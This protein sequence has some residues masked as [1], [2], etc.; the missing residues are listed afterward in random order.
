MNTARTCWMVTATLLSAMAAAAESRPNVLFLAVDDLR[1]ELACYGAVHVHSPHIDS[2]AATGRRFEA[3]Y[4]QQAVC[5]PSRTSLMTG[6]RPDTT[7][8]VGNHAHFRAQLPDVVTLPQYFRQH[9]Y[10][11]AAIGKIYHGVFPEGASRTKWDTMGDPPSWSVP[12]VRFGPRYYYTE[13]GIAAARQQF[14][15]MY[16]PP[17]PAPDDWTKKLVFGPATE[18]PDVADNVLYDGQVAD[19]AIAFLRQHTQQSGGQHKPL[20]LAVGFIKPHSPYVAPQKYFD[21]YQEMPLPAIDALPQG[22]PAF[23][24]HNSGELRRYTDQPAEGPISPAAQRRVRQAYYACVSYIDAQ[25]GRVLTALEETGLADNTIVVLLGDHGYHLGE[26]GLWGKTTN[27]ELDTRVPLIVRAPDMPAPGKS[28]A[29]LVELLDVYPTLAD[30]AG[31]PAPAQVEGVSFVP[32]LQ[33]PNHPGKTAAVSQ[34]PRG[35]RMGYSLRTSTHRLTQWVDQKTGQRSAT[36]LYHYAAAIDGATART[37]TINLAASRPALVAQLSRQLTP[38]IKPP[39]PEAGTPNDQTAPDETPGDGPHEGFESANPGSFQRLS[40]S[41]GEWSTDEGRTVIDNRHAATGRQSLQLTGGKKTIVR[42]RLND[43]LDTSGDLHFAAER[44]TRRAPF[45]FQ[46]EKLSDG[47]WTNVFDGSQVRVGRPFLSRVRV[48]LRDD[49]ITQ[50]RW[51]VTSPPG[52]GVLIDDLCLV[53]AGADDAPAITHARPA[54]PPVAARAEAVGSAFVMAPAEDKTPPARLLM[55]PVFSDHMVLQANVDVP[56][57]GK[58]VP[59]AP[60][61][62]QL[63]STSQTTRADA[64]GDWRL[65]LPPLPINPQGQP[66][67]ITSGSQKLVIRD[68]LL[69]EVWL[70]AGQ[71]NMEWRLQQSADAQFALRDADDHLLRLLHLKGGARGSSGRYTTAHIARL[72]PSAFFAGQ[73]QLSS[74][75]VAADFSAVAWYFGQHLR[76]RRDVPIGLICPALGGTPTEAWISQEALQADPELTGLVAG[77]WLDNPRLGEFCRSRGRA[78]LA[79]A[80]QA[81][82]PLPGDQH[83][84]NHSFKPGFVWNA[85]EDTR[86]FRVRG[87]I[88]YQGESNAESP[89]RVREHG[90]LLPL[91]IQQ[92]RDAQQC[93]DLPFLHVQLPALDRPEWPWMRDDQRRITERTENVG[94]VVTIDTGHRTNVHPT[95]KRPIGL[96]LAELAIGMTEPAR[97]ADVFQSPAVT[98]HAKDRGQLTVTFA[99]CG[100]GLRTTDGGAPRHFEVCGKDGRFHPATA[101]IVSANSVQLTCQSVSEPQHVRYAWQPW[102]EPAVNLINSGQ[103]PASP[104][105]TETESTSLARRLSAR[106]TD[107]RLPR[108][109]NILF[110]VSEDNSEHL[111]CYGESRVHTPHLDQLAAEGVRYTRAYVPYSVCSPSRAAFLTGLYPRQTGHIGLATHRFAMAV[112]YPTLPALLHEAGYYTGFLGKTHINPEHLVEDHIDHRAIRGA[113]FS[114]TTSITEYAREAARVFRTAQQRDQPFL[115]IVNFA[116]AHRK[117]VARSRAGFPSQQ[118]SDPVRP[119][120]WIGSDTPHLREEIRDYFNCMNRLDEGIGLVLNELRNAGQLDN[121]LIVYIS[122]HGADFPRGKGSVYE[123]GVRIPMIVRHPSQFL[124]GDVEEGFVTTLDLLP[125]MLKT[126]GLPV[127]DWLPG[128]P[129]QD[130]AAR[131]APLQPYV[132]TFTTGSSPNLLYVQFG[133]RDERYKLIRNPARTVNRLAAS[134]YVNSRIP[135]EQQ[136]HNFLHPA[137]LELYDLQSD[138]HEWHNLAES[139]QH[140]AMRDRL[141]QAMRAFQHRIG[142]PF[143]SE[144]NLN[145]F[146]QEQTD[147]QARDYRRADFHWPHRKMFELADPRRGDSQKTP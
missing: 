56:V 43:G 85:L 31:L 80:L 112:D 19:A 130:V 128:R 101:Q 119:F 118:L 115:L 95:A 14:Q 63:G 92:W 37:E 62:V 86:P 30:L 9:G 33:D 138:P 57:W 87:V 58:C 114:K 127:P 97:A 66:L 79:G 4:C 144:D 50:L 104:F 105:T 137:E 90:R 111:G 141:L 42:L 124:T 21:L 88:W 11:A 64:H 94:M 8:V 25:A 36:E 147:H 102:P 125:T 23:A 15:R 145:T 139:P 34:Y 59:H 7:G 38:F 109:P 108:P 106:H 69:G 55:P 3:A 146:L 47:T 44:W 81:G 22:A 140:R 28:T 68:V 132:H 83:G 41:L 113:N 142:D 18:A 123:H 65:R 73:W 110:L 99:H 117:F 120:A 133:I 12:A 17:D 135:P 75:T 100:A 53:P 129:L 143:V 136:Q 39:P 49:D 67:T 93:P 20:F 5:N 1:P 121:T 74:P 52:T 45:S 40:T 48:P 10:Q 26:Q 27:F 71:S 78:N 70:C 126:A 46:I 6:L 32:V 91:L 54:P 96:R 13:S 29:S 122:D 77:N 24:G 134:R 16:A 98:S 72:T 60:V 103:L 51:T 76:Q 89:R 35:Q 131:T 116:D 61:H 107:A 82:T 2:L 84:P